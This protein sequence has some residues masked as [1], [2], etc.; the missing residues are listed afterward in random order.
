MPL[1]QRSRFSTWLKHITGFRGPFSVSLDG[2][3]VPTYDTSL[4]DPLFDDEVAHWV[5]GAS[6]STLAGSFGSVGVQ[7]NTNAQAGTRAIVDGFFITPDGAAARSYLVGL[8]N[9]P[10]AG[11]GQTGV[12]NNFLGARTDNS[13]GPA[14]TFNPVVNFSRLNAVSIFT[15]NSTPFAVNGPANTQPFF[16]PFGK[17]PFVI[18]PGYA[19]AIECTTVNINVA[20]VAWGRWVA[21]QQ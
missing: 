4:S 6:S 7:L 17:I 1:I 16:D 21:D 3:L 11:I 20:M 14:N 12:R 10:N 2:G 18:S 9:A 13:F 15:A 8:A 19:F 5:A